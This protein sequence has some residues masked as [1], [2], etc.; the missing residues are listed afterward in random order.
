ME[1]GVMVLLDMGA[2]FR[3]L[4]ITALYQE[5]IQPKKPNE[6]QLLRYISV[7]C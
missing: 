2:N 7:S 5:P 4:K 1:W 6:L 3:A